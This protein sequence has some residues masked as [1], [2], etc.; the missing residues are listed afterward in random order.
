MIG[1]FS[2]NFDV[3]GKEYNFDIEAEYYAEVY[4]DDADGNRGQV[5]NCI[6]I[7]DIVIKDEDYCDLDSKTFDEV[8][9]EAE[10]DIMQ[11]LSE[12]DFDY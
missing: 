11:M 7:R 1:T 5:I 4:G 10:Q 6:E 8:W 12:E 9:N 2:Y 3:K